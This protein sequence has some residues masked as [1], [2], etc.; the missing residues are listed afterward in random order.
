MDFFESQDVA[1]RKTAVL[2]AYYVLAVVL[3]ILCVYAAF[4]GTFLGFKAKGGGDV[5]LEQLWRPEFFFWVVV[6]TSGVVLLGTLYRVAQLRT[7]GAAVARLL[8]GRPVSGNARDAGE[9]R[10][11]NIVEEMAI[12]SGTPVPSV[13]ML[14]GEQSINAFA[15]G[16]SPSDAVVAVTRGCVDQLSRDE[17]QG[18]VAHEFSHILNG[19]MRLNIKLIG[20]L[21]GILVISMIGYGIMRA[22]A[23]GGRSRSRDSKGGGSALLLFGLA[24]MVIGYV[25]V[26]FGKL[27]KSA[28]SRQREFLADASA[29]QFT[30][31]PDGIAGALKKIGGF[32]R[33]SRLR[34]AHAEEASHFFFSNG[35]G[36]S[37]S[38]LMAT[39]PPLAE[40]IRRLDP[41]F[42]GGAAQAARRQ[43]A[44]S[45]EAPVAGIAQEASFAV[46]PDDV[47]DSV[48]TPR[49]EHLAYAASLRASWPDSLVSA[50]HEPSGARAVLYAL[51]LNSEEGPR[52]RQAARLEQHADPEVARLTR[53]LQPDIARLGPNSRLPLAETSVGALKELSPAQYKAFRDNVEQLVAADEQID[54]FEYTIRRMIARQLDP[55]FGKPER[56]AVRHRDIK[57]LQPSAIDLLSCLAYWG[58][59]DQGA[60]RRAFDAGTAR[61]DLP[62]RL[63]IRPAADCGLRELDAALDALAAAAPGIKKRIVAACTACIGYDGRVTVEEAEVL[64]AV[65]DALDCPMPPFVP[66]AAVAAA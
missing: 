33:G 61:L 17:L 51:L 43:A 62:G 4:V 1:R 56:G 31:N 32:T 64:R 3:I 20:V 52:R 27:I 65:A 18:V 14:D 48:G 57:P 22:G 23:A 15:A 12:A 21:H 9:R 63:E 24:L 28:V 41:S 13:F 36:A 55:L 25:G 30:R 60:A 19:D 59:D 44:A 26:F 45:G 6:C 2:V 35:L 66:G 42:A 5:R 54:L 40:R 8:G 47:V 46:D 49:A 37:F 39:H 34:S 38:R 10:V 53:A 50:A 58:A 7:G 16:F 29:V 11:L